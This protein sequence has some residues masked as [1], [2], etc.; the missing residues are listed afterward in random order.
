MGTRLNGVC[1]KDHEAKTKE[2]Q[3]LDGFAGLFLSI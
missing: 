1:V 3:I 2:K